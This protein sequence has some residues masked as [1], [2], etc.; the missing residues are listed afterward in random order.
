MLVTYL[1]LC[2]H[3]P[4]LRLQTVNALF[5]VL[6]FACILDIDY[7]SSPPP[8]FVPPP[9]CCC[10]RDCCLGFVFLEFIKV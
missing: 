6:E 3:V 7:I 1:W 5:C 2:N 10:Y 8:R 4:N 9:F